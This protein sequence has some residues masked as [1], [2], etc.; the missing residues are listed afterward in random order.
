MQHMNHIKGIYLIFSSVSVILFPST[1]TIQL[2]IECGKGFLKET[3]ISK[4]LLRSPFFG[5]WMGWM[6]YTLICEM[7]KQ[8]NCPYDSLRWKK[9]QH[10]KHLIC[11]IDMWVCISYFSPWTDTKLLLNDRYLLMPISQLMQMHFLPYIVSILLSTRA[12]I[13]FTEE[14]RNWHCSGSLSIVSSVRSSL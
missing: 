2:V 13:Y 8:H 6:K 14:S 3:S 12:Q 4:G 11:N 5:A 1:Y 7:L 9:T 10:K